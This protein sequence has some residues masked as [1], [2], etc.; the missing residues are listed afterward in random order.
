M[1]LTVYIGPLGSGK[2][3]KL[4]YRASEHGDAGQVVRFI[5]R[6]PGRELPE[7]CEVVTVDDLFQVGHRRGSVLCVDDAHLFENLVG[8]LDEQLRRHA[9]IYV[10][11]EFASYTQHPIVEVTK[12]VAIADRVVHCTASCAVCKEPAAHQIHLG[13][14]SGR[15]SMAGKGLVQARCRKCL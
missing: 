13:H 14:T 7:C 2:S 3:T 5:R 1:S 11:A 9:V 6:R 15:V 10:A 8:W 12:V 4:A